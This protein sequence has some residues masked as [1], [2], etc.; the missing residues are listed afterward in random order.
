[1]QKEC[2][3]KRSP[4]DHWMFANLHHN[5]CENGSLRRNRPS[6]GGPRITMDHRIQNTLFHAW[7]KL[8]SKESEYHGGSSSHLWTTFT[9]PNTSLLSVFIQI[10]MQITKHPVVQWG[11]FRNTIFL[12]LEFPSA[13]LPARCS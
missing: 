11:S 4:L 12:H 1:M 9:V 7:N 6:E 5:L 10:V 3:A 8:C 2:I 13:Y